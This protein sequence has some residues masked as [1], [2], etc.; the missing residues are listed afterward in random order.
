MIKGCS[1][2][3]DGKFASSNVGQAVCN[4]VRETNDH[5]ETL[6]VLRSYC[7]WLRWKSRSE[8][9]FD[10]DDR[11]KQ[12]LNWRFGLRRWCLYW[13]QNGC[14]IDFSSWD[15]DNGSGGNGDDNVKEGDTYKSEVESSHV[16]KLVSTSNNS[17][18]KRM[19]PTS[20][21]FSYKRS[22]SFPK[23]KQENNFSRWYS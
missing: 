17:L 9:G 3:D 8:G 1:F 15:F 10:E 13:Q 11:F 18:T 5:A 23:S 16:I 4:C 19:F 20:L 12:Q 21:C 7:R 6:T 2:L 22:L 14:I